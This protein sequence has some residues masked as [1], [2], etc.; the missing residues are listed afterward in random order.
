MIRSRL[1]KYANANPGKEVKETIEILLYLWKANDAKSCLS[2]LPP[3]LMLFSKDNKKECAPYQ[4][5]AGDTDTAK[6]STP[7]LATGVAGNEAMVR[8]LIREG[9][10]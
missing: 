8:F 10:T 5:H 2:M 4:E 1:E 9:P 3:M 7:L 6:G